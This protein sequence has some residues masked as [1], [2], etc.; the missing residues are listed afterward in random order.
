MTGP[1]SSLKILDFSTLLPGPY[2]TMMLADMGAEVVSVE[3]VSPKGLG[4]DEAF[5]PMRQYLGRSKRSL[6]LD[7]KKE[8]SKKVINI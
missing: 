6:A 1:L 7:L 3:A 5:V 8:E 4:F 2:G